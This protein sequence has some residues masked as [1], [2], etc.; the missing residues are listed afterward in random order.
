MSNTQKALKI[1]GR[2]G[3]PYVLGGASLVSGCLTNGMVRYGGKRGDRRPDWRNGAGLLPLT[4]SFT[5]DVNKLRR[6][7]RMSR[8]DHHTIKFRIL[9][10]T[11][12]AFLVFTS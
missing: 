12:C 10:L 3:V 7:Q 2:S 8:I 11:P 4:A 1:Q 5:Q 9:P 6:I